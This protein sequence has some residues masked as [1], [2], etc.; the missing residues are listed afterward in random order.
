M[1]MWIM[2]IRWD[3]TLRGMYDTNIFAS[4][5]F[6]IVCWYLISDFTS[7]KADV[8]LAD[9]VSHH[10]TENACSDALLVLI[11]IYC[12]CIMCSR[13][14]INILMLSHIIWYL[15]FDSTSSQNENR[16][17][18][19]HLRWQQTRVM[20]Q[21]W[22]YLRRAI[23]E[24]SSNKDT[25][26]TVKIEKGTTVYNISIWAKNLSYLLVWLPV[27]QINVRK[28]NLDLSSMG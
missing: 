9:H 10:S 2:P 25:E 13:Y 17:V 12:T 26:V 6:V 3:V 11:T 16:T 7:A 21:W 22:H 20:H 5:C 4:W 23:N 14:D 28:V 8:K 15:V 19:Q 18:S 1:Q 27:R 24:L